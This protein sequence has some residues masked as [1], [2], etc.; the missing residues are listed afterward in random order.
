MD[1]ALDLETCSTVERGTQHA[2]CPPRQWEHTPSRYLSLPR[3]TGCFLSLLVPYAVTVNPG[4]SSQLV[5]AL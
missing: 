4:Y 1:W 2:C 3:V 5:F